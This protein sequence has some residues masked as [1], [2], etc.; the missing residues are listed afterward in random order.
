M[1]LPALHRSSRLGL[2]PP[3]LVR[4]HTTLELR[5]GC[6][7]TGS[8][9]RC[10]YRGTAL[11]SLQHPGCVAR[12]L[13]R[14]NK[15]YKQCARTRSV[16]SHHDE[17]DQEPEPAAPRYEEADSRFERGCS[18]TTAIREPAIC[19]PPP[20]DRID[21]TRAS[22]DQ[23]TRR[24]GY[25]RRAA[26]RHDRRN[27]QPEGVRKHPQS[28]F[29]SWWNPRRPP[30]LRSSKVLRV[31]SIPLL[32]LDVAIRAHT[33]TLHASEWFHQ[34]GQCSVGSGSGIVGDDD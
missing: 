26:L 7:L 20:V 10:S 21:G 11:G 12:K 17:T 19:F 34:W 18:P 14:G 15:P 23:R 3:S 2:V 16:N 8:G 6:P 25:E 4:F 33:R 22:R 29:H 30:S 13:E 32:T 28:N 1:A 5:R 24:P 9:D 27:Q 31:A